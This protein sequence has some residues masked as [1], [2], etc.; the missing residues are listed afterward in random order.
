MMIG[1]FFF[2]RASVKDRTKQIQLIP[3]ES[4][5]VLLKELQEYFETRAYKITSVDQESKQVT[6]E[7]LVRPS[8]FLAIL[9]TFLALVGL[10]C[11]V[12]I[13]FLLFP[14]VNGV[15]WLFL[16]FAPIAGVFY[17]RKAERFEKILLQVVVPN[18]GGFNLVSVIAHRDELIQLQENLSV[19]ILD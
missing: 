7:G 2:I 14:N 12:L 17:W 11:L 4:E 13:L 18:T 3:T 6:F 5:D 8:F 19:Q 1:L 15:F 9:L 10:S 16:L